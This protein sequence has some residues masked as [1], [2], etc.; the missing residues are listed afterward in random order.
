MRTVKH[1]AENHMLLFYQRLTQRWWIVTVTLIRIESEALLSEHDNEQDT[2]RNRE[3]LLNQSSIAVLETDLEIE[4]YQ[5]TV[6]QEL[7]QPFRYLPRLH[8]NISGNIW[9]GNTEA[10]Q[11][12]NS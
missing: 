11:F 10:L 4:L 9:N 2:S 5:R 12:S 1:S 7:P 3:M 8:L 6:F